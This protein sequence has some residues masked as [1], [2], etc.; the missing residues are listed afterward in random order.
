MST[1]DDPPP[2]FGGDEVTPVR[3]APPPL[4]TLPPWYIAARK[5]LGV[6]EIAGTKHNPRILE[7][8][9]SCR[10]G[11][12]L[13]DETPWCSSFANFIM[14]K[15]GLM[16]SGK[17]NARSWLTWGQELQKPVPGCIVVFWRDSPKSAKGHVGFYVGGQG[18][19]ILVLGGN[20]GNAVSVTTYPRARLLGYRWPNGMPV[21]A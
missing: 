15:A 18:G 3:A 17:R 12:V 9:K 13:D 2:I 7:Y 10:G 16:G 20:Q 6:K 8:H 5:E 1:Q 19:E 14:L 11:D 21:P 4:P